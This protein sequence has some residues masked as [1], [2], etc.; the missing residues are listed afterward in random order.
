M[1]SFLTRLR[2]RLKR[3]WA[4]PPDY[5]NA[6]KDVDPLVLDIY[7]RVRP[8]TMTNLLRVNALV[9]SVDH[10]IRRGVAGAFVECGVWRGGS[11]LAMLLRLR[12]LGVQDRDVYLYDN[13]EGMP[14]PA[15]ADTSPYERPAFVTWQQATAAGRRA[16]EQF[17]RPEIFTFE[18]V[19]ETVLATGYPAT[20]I[21]FVK[22]DILET[23]PG[24]APAQI[25]LLRLDTDWYE[26]TRHELLHL[27]PRLNPGGVLLIDDYGHW[28]GCRKAVDEYFSTGG[29]APVLLNRVDYAARLAVKH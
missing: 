2:T 11:V 22:G 13:F 29:A 12:Q 5:N 28:D 7:Q 25:A 4:L 16:W 3:L 17:F 9:Q 21:H 20:R 15:A 19:R 6:I 27:Y 1:T 26:S 10:V 14:A 8:Y 24:T 23:I 18:Q